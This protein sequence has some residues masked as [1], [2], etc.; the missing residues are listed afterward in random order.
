VEP[1]GA[2]KA[3]LTNPAADVKFGPMVRS[4][5]SLQK[6][7][8]GDLARKAGVSVRAIRYYEELG[9]VSPETHSVGGFRLYSAESLRRLQVI[10][11]LKEMGLSL[12]EIREI[13]HAK[14]PGA[15]DRQ[16]VSFLAGVLGER[17]TQ[18]ETKIAAL[19]KMKEELSS[20]LKILRSC[21]T[22][23]HKVLLDTMLCG[24]C[25]NLGPRDS[26]PD[27]LEVLLG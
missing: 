7:Q 24:D 14:K 17:L 21:E 18:V 16:T 15:G 20:A 2:A 23:D 11:C 19:Q 4:I 3:F 22:C 5:E 9:L 1:Y 26:V 8:I 6:I 27:T 10:H 25:A 12:V 13:F